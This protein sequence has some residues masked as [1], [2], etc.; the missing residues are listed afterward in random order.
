MSS[1][2]DV[3]A[4]LNLPAEDGLPKPAPLMSLRL[5]G[6]AD[7]DTTQLESPG[8]K[9]PRAVSDTNP[10][11][12]SPEDKKISLRRKVQAL[13]MSPIVDEEDIEEEQQD[14][15]DNGDQ[16]VEKDSPVQE[17]KSAPPQGQHSV[18]RENASAI[19]R[20][21]MLL[22]FETY[23]KGDSEAA[24]ALFVASA[25]H[26]DRMLKEAEAAETASSV[27][28]LTAVMGEAIEEVFSAA[29]AHA[30]DE[31]K[32]GLFMDDPTETERNDLLAAQEAE[33]A[34]LATVS[35]YKKDR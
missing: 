21:G 22:S 34:L 3:K 1:K 14:Y 30:A 25:D 18:Y 23:R 35:K 4:E 17:D 16:P 10:P 31:A 29:S 5:S 32:A 33:A 13:F 28:S 24:F 8:N 11:P 26:A 20:D 7:T 9:A 12:K 2:H 15:E 19:I 27:P 6:E